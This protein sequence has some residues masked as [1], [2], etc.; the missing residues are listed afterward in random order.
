MTPLLV[1]CAHPDDEF[2]LYPW[3]VRAVKDKRQI[4]IVWLTD[5]GWGG[6][7]RAR[8]CAE[9]REVLARLGV[10]E[11]SLH[12]LGLEWDIPDGRLHEYLDDALGR[13]FLRFPARFR[14]CDV[15]VPAWEGGHQDHDAAH[16]FGVQLA[17]TLNAGVRQYSL[18][19]GR[20]LPGPFFNVLSPLEE[21]G[22]AVVTET[23]LRERVQYAALC[24]RYRS[25][26]KSFVGLLPLYL[27]RMTRP[28]AFRLQAVQS[29]RLTEPPHPGRLLY[30][31]RGAMSWSEFAEA[32]Q[33]LRF[34]R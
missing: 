31:R 9:S 32:T 21:N 17:R 11:T 30:E 29:E 20:G 34:H 6:Q 23:S 25:Q 7:D 19:N 10:E 15:L 28:N 3:L 18:Y 1:V 4:D 22:A 5:G 8:R 13:F 2:A 14:T 16:I 33:R 24:L 27:L 12:F 26:W